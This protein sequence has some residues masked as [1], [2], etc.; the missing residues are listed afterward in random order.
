MTKS[1]AAYGPLYKTRGPER[2]VKRFPTG[3][4]GL[5]KALNGGLLP[6]F[7]GLTSVQEKFRIKTE[8]M[9]E[10]KESAYEEGHFSCGCQFCLPVLGGL[11]SDPSSWRKAGFAGNGECCGW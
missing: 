2:G 5:D 6:E 11:L 1:I 7:P 8:Q 9:F 3:I 4:A 10:R